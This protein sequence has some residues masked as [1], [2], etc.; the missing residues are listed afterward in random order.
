MA[1]PKGI[2]GTPE[3]LAQLIAGQV[4]NL[5]IESLDFDALLGRININ[6]LLERIDVNELLEQV[7]VNRLMGQIDVN[8]LMSDIDL[9]ALVQHMELEALIARSTT[10]AMGAVLDV[11]RRVGVGLDDFVARL[12][13][14]LLRRGHGT[15]PLGPVLLVGEL[16]RPGSEG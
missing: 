13:D 2:R 10:S 6:A 8:A 12:V 4:V 1:T 15:R 7:D 14:R 5:V 16:A 9:D 3:R 11:V